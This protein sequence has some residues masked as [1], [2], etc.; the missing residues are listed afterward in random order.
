MRLW[1]YASGGCRWKLL[2]EEWLEPN[3][4]RPYSVLARYHE[5]I[6]CMDTKATL[7]SPKTTES[8]YCVP[9]KFLTASTVTNE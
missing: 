4:E 3:K 2:R 9:D 8:F 5:C 6:Y 7:T 1:C